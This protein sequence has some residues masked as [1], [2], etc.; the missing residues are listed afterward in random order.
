MERAALGG[1]AH[2]EQLFSLTPAEISA[3]LKREN[4]RRYQQDLMAWISARYILLAVHCPE[5]MPREPCFFPREQPDMTDD[6]I[7]AR[8]RRVKGAMSRDA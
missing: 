7:K 2:P 6:E 3:R 4:A 1:M 5:K 8:M